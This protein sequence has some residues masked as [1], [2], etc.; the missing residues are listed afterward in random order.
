[1]F[2]FI[3]KKFPHLRSSARSSFTTYKPYGTKSGIESPNQAKKHSYAVSYL[4]N[5]FGFAPEKALSASKY[6]KFASPDKPE[7]VLSFLENHG[8]T[9]SQVSTVVKRYPPVLLCDP[10]NTLLPK[11]E[12]FRSLGFAE[13]DFTRILCVAPAILKRSLEN[14]LLPTVD[15][16]K[17][18]ISSPEE[19]RLSIKRCPHIFFPDRQAF[20]EDNVQLLREMGV[21]ELKIAHYVQYQPCLFIREKDKFRKMLEEIKGMGFEPTRN[22]FIVAVHVFSSL[23][24]LTWEKKIGIY[25]KWGLSEDE[26]L[27][28]FSRHPM[29]MSYSE[30]NI[31]GTMDFLVNRMGFATSD[32]MRYP[33]IIS[34]SLKERIIPRC[35]VYQTLLAKGLLPAN[36]ITVLVRILKVSEEKFLT[37][38]VEC[39][40]KEVPELP[41]LYQLSCLSG[42]FELSMVTGDS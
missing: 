34:Y 7:S 31:M 32:V 23:N 16:L 29:F 12:F 38:F 5:T 6:T 10:Q 26:I 24:K 20:M 22:M 14:Q 27:E 42:W 17:K 30:E 35:F 13:K 33:L 11:I 3:C 19:I 37:K 28:A 39:Y 15:F 2:N 4:V 9:K 25:K 1:M 8:F 40:G 41:K 21:P 36:D 18:F